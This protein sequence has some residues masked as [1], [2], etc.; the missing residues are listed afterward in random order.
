[1]DGISISRRILPTVQPTDM[2]AWVH[3]CMG[4]WVY[5]CM[6]VSIYRRVD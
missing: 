4:V 1:M 5:E 2:G 6:G 3:G